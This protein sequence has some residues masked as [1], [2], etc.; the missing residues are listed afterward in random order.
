MHLERVW[1]HIFSLLRNH[2]TCTTNPLRVSIKQV[3]WSSFIE[4]KFTHR[5]RKPDDDS[6]EEEFYYTE[7]EEESDSPSPTSPP[8]LSHRDMA[9]PPH[10][11]PEY[12]RQIVGN[13]RQGLLLTQTA[14]KPPLPQQQQSQHQQN[15]GV[16]SST[17]ANTILHHNYSWSQTS[18]V[19]KTK[20]LFFWDSNWLGPI[21]SDIATKTCTIIAAPIHLVRPIS[22]INVLN[23]D[24]RPPYG[25]PF[26][27]IRWPISHV[28]Q[29]PQQQQ[30]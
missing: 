21:F 10:E 2:S 17:I 23:S 4:K 9:R 6:D 18:P 16:H 22:N 14:V 30:Q 5:P 20:I 19:S 3:I 15:G 8:T 12:Q 7:I 13:Y 29:P 1:R 24:C 27:P 28:S 11:D 25:P 26:R